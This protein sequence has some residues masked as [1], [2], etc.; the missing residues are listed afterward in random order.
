MD[1]RK[2]FLT[3][4]QEKGIDKLIEL[5]GIAEAI[6]GT[7]IRVADNQGLERMKSKVPAEALPIVYEVIDEVLKSLGIDK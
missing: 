4:N 2:G 6:D 5:K 3:P 1:D 7:A